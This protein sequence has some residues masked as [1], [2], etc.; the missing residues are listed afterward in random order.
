MDQIPVAAPINQA[1]SV[2]PAGACQMVIAITM[3][4]TAPI[5]TTSHAVTRKTASNTSN[6]ASGISATRVLPRV[7][8]RGLRCWTK[9]DAAV[10]HGRQP[11]V[12]F[13]ALQSPLLGGQND[14]DAYQGCIQ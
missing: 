1:S 12:L 6:N 7:E 3:V 8:L 5:V 9:P 4:T 14:G 13:C 10:N 11:S 2:G